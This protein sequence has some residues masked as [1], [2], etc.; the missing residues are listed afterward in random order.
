MIPDQ[1]TRLRS[2]MHDARPEPPHART[3]APTR[4]PKLVAIASGKGGVGKTLLSVGIARTLAFLNHRVTLIDADHGTAN[5]DLM[6][7]LNPSARLGAAP[8]EAIRVPDCPKLRLVAGSVGASE[9]RAQ[10]NAIRRAFAELGRTTDVFVVDLGAGITPGIL[11]VLRVAWLPIIVA[12]PEPTACADAYALY[13]SLALAGGTRAGGTRAG[14]LVN[15]CTSDREGQE[16]FERFAAASDRFIGSRPA[17][18]GTL[19]SD[20]GVRDAVRE[21]RPVVS[22]PFASSVASLARRC[23]AALENDREAASAGRISQ[24]GSTRVGR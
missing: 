13:K 4:A 6:L 2:L 11:A 18:L 17:R 8:I 24:V 3:H 21:R 10:H 22:G 23:A 14:L 16:V 9:S 7:G 20:T 15:Q 19:P 1:A 5:A 12:T